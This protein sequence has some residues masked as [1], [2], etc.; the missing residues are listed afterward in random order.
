MGLFVQNLNMALGIF[1]SP[2]S[3]QVPRFIAAKID[4]DSAGFISGTTTR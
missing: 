3:K 1:Q 2:I 4:A